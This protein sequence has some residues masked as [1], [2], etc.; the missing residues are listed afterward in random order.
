MSEV[1]GMNNYGERLNARVRAYNK[2]NARANELHRELLAIFRPFVGKKILTN[3]GFIAKLRPQLEALRERESQPGRGRFQ[4]YTTSTT[5]TLTYV[6]KGWDAYQGEPHGG[7]YA[8]VGRNGNGLPG[9][10]LASVNSE[11]L[12]LRTDYDA[13]AVRVLRKAAE[14]A[15][16]KAREAESALYPFGKY[17]N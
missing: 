17:D 8:E 13:E 12:A 6:L 16:D 9:D 3:S 15:A 10:H 2:V 5:Y 11:P 7:S 4:L 1:P 14:A